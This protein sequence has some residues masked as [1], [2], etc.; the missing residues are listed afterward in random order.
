VGAEERAEGGISWACA[1]SREVR[2]SNITKV[3][4]GEK[5]EGISKAAGESQKTKIILVLGRHW[6]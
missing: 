4:Y 2:G 5:R 1:S 6:I 3:P